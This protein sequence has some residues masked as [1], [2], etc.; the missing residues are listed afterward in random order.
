VWQQ[1]LWNTNIGIDQILKDT[2]ILSFAAKWLG[3]KD[4]IYED[5][6]KR[7]NFSDDT[8]LLKSIWKLMDEADILVVQNGSAFD[9]PSVMA[10]MMAKG[11]RP[12]SPFRVVDTCTLAR[13]KFN[14]TSNKLAFLAEAMGCKV[15]KQ[16]HRKFPGIELWQECLKGN[17][18]AWEEMESYNKA[19]VEVLEEVYLKM[20][21]WMAEHPNVGVYMKGGKLHCPK[22]GSSSLQKRGIRTTNISEYQQY[23]C[24]NCGGYSRARIMLNSV[25]HRR[26]QL[27]N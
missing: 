4:I 6:S 24:N 9:V 5:L 16:K 18:K 27:A 7:R 8:P 15:K 20:R 14:F 22:C 25:E 11:L 2:N 17:Q 26:N 23:V 12:P 10:R 19:D 21:P 3:E 13:K 1:R